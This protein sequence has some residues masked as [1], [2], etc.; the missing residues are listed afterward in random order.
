MITT[1]FAGKTADGRDVNAYILSDGK[2]SA[3]ILNYGG[4]IRKL[5]IEK[6]GK[7]YNVV[8]GFDD[9]ADYAKFGGYIGAFIGRIGNRIGKG[10]FTLDGK[11]YQLNLNDGN[12]HLHGGIKG[13]NDKILNAEIQGD[14]LVLSTVSPDGEENYPGTLQA[15]V[16]YTLKDGALKIEYTAI[17]DKK[18]LINLTNHAYFNLN[19]E[20]VG[21]ILEHTLQIDADAVTT[22]DEELIPHGEFKAV[23]G[24]PFDFRKPKKMGKDIAD[25]SDADIKNGGGYDINFV[26][27]GRNTYRKIAEV[28]GDKSGI[29]MEVYTDLPG[30]QFYSGC[31]L[32]NKFY[33]KYEAF[34]LETQCL[35]NAVNCPEYEKIGK[36]IFDANEVYHTV[37]EYRFK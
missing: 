12:N 17:S 21:N 28:C 15:K 8:L 9:V 37:T 36:T 25:E 31:M 26:L 10:K 6:D 1:K 5:N 35:P 18:T 30:V 11:E 2:N 3:E 27:N 29:I 20:G 23:E 19:G 16:C 24:T 7:I 14:T 4:I 13:F 32:E 33:H 22:A 34:C